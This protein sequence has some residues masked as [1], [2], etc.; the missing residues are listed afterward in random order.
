METIIQAKSNLPVIPSGIQQGELWANA[1]LR[2]R[3][4]NC[5]SKHLISIVLS[6]ANVTIIYCL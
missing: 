5:H 2:G 1:D 4:L 6:P 3:G